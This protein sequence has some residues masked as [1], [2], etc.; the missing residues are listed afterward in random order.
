MITHLCEAGRGREPIPKVSAQAKLPLNVIAGYCEPAPVLLIARIKRINDSESEHG[1]S[2]LPSSQGQ[3][4]SGAD[5]GAERNSAKEPG[6]REEVGREVGGEGEN[7]RCQGKLNVIS[8]G[9]RRR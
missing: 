4:R 8:G 1:R 9:R 5:I 2:G 3:R 6:E 7:C